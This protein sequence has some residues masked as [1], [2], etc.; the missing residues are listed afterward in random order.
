MKV[1]KP[2]EVGANKANVF[3]DFVIKTFNDL[4]TAKYCSGSAKVYQA[5]LVEAMIENSPE[6][7]TEDDILNNNFLDVEDCYRSAGWKV[8]YGS[9]GYNE[10]YR[11]FFLFEP[12]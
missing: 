3:P 1:I 9:L 5:D 4:I 11:S 10:Q 7:I 2:D 8:T 12:K 6:P